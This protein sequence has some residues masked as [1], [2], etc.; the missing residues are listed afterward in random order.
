MSGLADYSFEAK[1]NWREEDVWNE[2]AF[3]CCV[4]VENA[5]VVVLAG[6]QPLDIELGVARGF[7]AENFLL[8]DI[9]SATVKKHRRAK[10]TVIEG[11]IWDVV[12][13]WR[14]AAPRKIDVLIADTCSDIPDKALCAVFNQF[15]FSPYA[16]ICTNFQRGRGVQSYAKFKEHTGELLSPFEEWIT[17]RNATETKVHRGKIFLSMYAYVCEELLYRVSNEVN[18]LSP[19]SKEAADYVA[20][21]CNWQRERL[22][23]IF[24][25]ACMQDLRRLYDRGVK[26]SVQDYLFSRLTEFLAHYPGR[27]ALDSF[28]ASKPLISQYKSKAEKGVYM[29]S[30]IFNRCVIPVAS[31]AVVQRILG[32]PRTKWHKPTQRKIAAAN[33]VLTRRGAA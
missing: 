3:R 28:N 24:Q 14:D 25:L 6:P 12:M 11:D 16:V 7:R 1:N 26:P 31:H 33:A 13:N 20:G 8:C 29:D 9:D 10:R 18:D 17:E 32:I 27:L 30:V 23:P 2:I 5:L 22:P 21:A 4:P 15:A 19:C